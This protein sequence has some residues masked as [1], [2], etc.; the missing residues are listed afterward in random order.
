MSVPGLLLRF[1]VIYVLLLA[2]IAVAFSVLG[3]KSNSGVN[4]AAL[5]GA[6]LGACSWF[7]SKNG[8]FLEARERKSAILGMWGIDV[9]LQVVVAM[10]VGAASGT[11][12]PLMPMLLATA[13]IGLVHGVLI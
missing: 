4:S 12:L 10:A 13:F 6:V 3:L 9:G 8:R 11:R 7:G 1:A 5:I 2:G